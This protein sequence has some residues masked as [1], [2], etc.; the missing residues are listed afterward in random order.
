MG[1]SIL[2]NLHCHSMFSD[3]ADTPERLAKKLAAAGV[4]FAALTDHDSI[5]GLPDFQVAL[6][7]YGIGFLPGVELTTYFQGREVHLLGYGF[8]PEHAEL[9]ATLRSLRQVQSLDVHSIAGSLRKA[10]NNHGTSD[11]DAASAAPNGYLKTADA[12][13]LLQQAG[14]RVFLAHPLQLESDP[15]DLGSL[16]QSLKVLGLDGIEAY[17]TPYSPAE[18]SGLFALADRYGLLVSAGTDFHSDEKQNPP[19]YVEMPRPDWTRFRDAVLSGSHY[20]RRLDG[21]T[22]EH[23]TSPGLSERFRVRSPLARLRPFILR[24]VFPTL[25]A[26]ILFLAAFWG[27]ILPSFEQTLLDRKREMI[28]ELTNTSWSILSSYQQEETAGE[29]SREQ[30]Q[31][32][33]IAR[34]E[35]LR[36]G[37][38]GKDYFWIQTFEPAMIMHPYRPDL[39][40]KNLQQ[41]TD[42]RGV[43]IFVE[44]AALVNRDGEGYIDYVWQWKDDPQRVEPKESFVKGFTPWGWIIGTGIYIDDVQLEI[45]RIERSLTHASLAISGALVLL[46]AFVL[47]QSLQIEKARQDVVDTLSESSG[48]YHAL[49]EAATEGTLLVLKNRCKYANPTFLNMIGTTVQQLE[50]LE[51]EDL[52]PDLSGNAAVWE[53]LQQSGDQI[54]L[55]GTPLEGCLQNR[56]GSCLEC[57]LAVNPIR[58]A[59]Q[60]G[61]ILLAK[62]VSAL[63]AAHPAPGASVNAHSLPIGFFRAMAVRRGVFLEMNPAGRTLLAHLYTGNETQPALVDLFPDAAEFE[64]F[65]RILHQQRETAKVP[66]TLL[67]PDA[68]VRYI[69][70][71]A[72]LVHE[73]H[74]RSPIIVGIL[75]D[76][77]TATR[78]EIERDALIQKLQSSLLFLHEPIANLK[79]ELVVCRLD[80]SI[81]DAARLMTQRSATAAVVQTETGQAIGIIT[82]HDLRERVLASR[83]DPAAQVHSVMS[84][85]LIRIQENAKIYEA[86]LRMEEEGVRHLAVETE[87]GRIVNILNSKSLFQFQRYGPI[88][89]TR[90]I[91]RAGTVEAAAQA[92]LRR[93]SLV[94][95][96]VS[97]GARPRYISE[98]LSSICDSTTQR[99]IELTVGDI[100]TPPAP[101]TFLAMGSQGRQE[102]TLLT[103]QDHGIIYQANSEND[104]K[105]LAAYFLA[106]GT[107]VS[108]GL[109]QAGYHYCSGSVM[110]SNPD[111]CRPLPDWISWFDTW[112]RTAEPQEILDLNIFFDFRAIYGDSE[113]ASMLRDH[114]HAS[115]QQH[116]AFFPHFARQTLTFKP[117]IRLPG[118]IYL[119]GGGLERGTELNLKDAMMPI[120]SFARLYALNQDL[121]ITNTLRRIETLEERNILRHST[122]E[123]LNAAYDFL[124]Q[125]RLQVQLEN[126]Q[127]GLPPGNTVRPDRLSSSQQEML[128]LSFSQISAV[129]KKVSYD[130]LGGM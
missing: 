108:D 114:V 109:H 83:Q 125:L 123:E 76:T 127:Q 40:G 128:R 36:Y 120:V 73:N 74:T 27:Y 2:V 53:A 126:L 14:G 130:F 104:K 64:G 13:A 82:D 71:T 52:L 54:H 7:K 63:A 70:L 105:E 122:R 39:N 124:M 77:T 66:L 65:L 75:E 6:K 69:T 9:Q 8:N 101:F 93:T 41:I 46:L 10:G 37:P 4:R 25:L 89:L 88:V 68:S 26:I 98:M 44:F 23:S 97:S 5:E 30:A 32:L 92:S 16:V 38:E 106:L 95:A 102:Q 67:Q 31:A 78:V 81:A 107:R 61:F 47:Q 91:E 79:Q 28:R 56:D 48:R 57:I 17:Y 72:S 110:A 62:D 115:L 60:D 51:L 20:T 59:G 22:E 112:L 35:T 117:P 99:L 58:I 19:I 119:G 12:I 15:D 118:N 116:P 3:G 100:G 121:Y 86:L 111:W 43:P 49:A 85:P 24:I 11:F 80:I 96:L 90:E 34:I 21:H 55:N 50:L 87:D 103:D 42:T 84:A 113:P 18:Q 33:A 29:L 94:Q 45:A 129:Q 1:L